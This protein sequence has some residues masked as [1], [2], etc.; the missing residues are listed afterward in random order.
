VVTPMQCKN[1]QRCFHFAWLECETCHDAFIVSC[2]AHSNATA[3]LFSLCLM[4]PALKPVHTG[5]HSPRP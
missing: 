5:D 1:C 2:T 3:R 4:Y